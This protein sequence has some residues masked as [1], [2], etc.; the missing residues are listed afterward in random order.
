MPIHSALLDWSILDFRK[1]GEKFL[2]SE[3]KT[4]KSGP[5]GTDFGRNFSK[6]KTTIGLPAA[7]TF[8]SF[9]HTVSTRLRNQ[10]GDL[11]ELWIDALLGHE[12]SQQEPRGHDLSLRH[13]N[14]KSQ[15]NGRSC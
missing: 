12:A 5:R 8:H 1:D 2:F 13:C 14:G 9:R 7:I 10:T 15:A 4:P 6:F 3:L 11:R